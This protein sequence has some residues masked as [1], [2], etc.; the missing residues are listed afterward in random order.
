MCGVCLGNEQDDSLKT[1][2]R[3]VI[4]PDLIQRTIGSQNPSELQN[5]HEVQLQLVKEYHDYLICC[6]LKSSSEE[7]AAPWLALLNAVGAED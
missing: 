2:D 4:G 7:T 3:W 6:D 1:V 5:L